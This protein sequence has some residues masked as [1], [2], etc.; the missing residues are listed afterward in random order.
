M[1]IADAEGHTQLAELLSHQAGT[2]HTSSSPQASVT[3]SAPPWQPQSPPHHMGSCATSWSPPQQGSSHARSASVRS[4]SSSARAVAVAY[5]AIYTS[6]SQRPCAE[7]SSGR[8]GTRG[9]PLGPAGSAGAHQG[10]QLG[11]GGEQDSDS[12]SRQ[13]DPGQAEGAPQIGYV[14]AALSFVLGKLQVPRPSLQNT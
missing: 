3:P 11:Q 4:S 14:P 12:G 13:G 2:H 7:A 8:E 10:V 1:S 6:A 5:P 9:P